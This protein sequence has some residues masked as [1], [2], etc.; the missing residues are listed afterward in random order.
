[1]SIRKI[2]ND[3]LISFLWI[4]SLTVFIIIASVLGILYLFFPELRLVTFTLGLILFMVMII[5]ISYLKVFD[6]ENSGE[7]VI[8]SNYNLLHLFFKNYFTNRMELPLEKIIGCEVKKIMLQ[9][10]LLVHVK[11]HN[12]KIMQ[13]FFSLQYLSEA[14]IQFIKMSLSKTENTNT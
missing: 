10:Y 3:I 6:F 9:K 12:E 4:S 2:S 11:R 1:M 5:F 7:L 8:I 14:N 13:V